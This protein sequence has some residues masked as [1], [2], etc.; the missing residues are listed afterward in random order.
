MATAGRPD[1]PSNGY[2]FAGSV[3]IGVATAEWNSEITHALRDG[4]VRV[5]HDAGV[6]NAQV[7]CIQVPGAF[8]LPLACAW[9]VNEGR[10]DA[11]IALGSVIRGETPHFDFVCQAAAEGT[12]RVGLDSRK[13]VLFGVLTDDTWDQAK[14]RSGGAHGNKG[15]DCAAACLAM[16]A[17]KH[18]LA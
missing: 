4:A 12:M 10:C 18:N 5:L 2:K 14:A 13:P 3:R 6:P 15:E 17:L 9:L 11:A 8:E 1:G 16:L 7:V